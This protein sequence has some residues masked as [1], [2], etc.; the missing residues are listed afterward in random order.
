MKIIIRLIALILFLLLSLYIVF[1]ETERYES[2]S[3]I[4]LKDLTEKQE[5]NL[6]E[7][8]LGKGSST[9]QDSK[10]IELYM[11][12]NEMYDFL[13]EKFHLTKHYS[14]EALDPRQRLYVDALLPMARVT[15][16]N[17]LAKYNAD[18]TIA[19]DDPSGTLTIS[20]V[21][22]DPKLAK[23]M[24]ES[25]YAR[26][27]EIINGFA[28]ENAKVALYFIED[29][30]KENREEFTL[31]IKKLIAYQNKHHTIDPSLDVE[32]KS[33]ILAEL[34]S[35]LIKSQV[36]Y[37]SKLKS[38]NPKG[39]EM[40]MLKETIRTL[41][42][43]ILRVNTQMVG[44]NKKELNKNVFDFEL[45]KSDMEFAKEVY[46]QTLINQEKLKLEVSQKS[47]HLLV[48][49]KPSLADDYTY[50]N[51]IWDVFKLFIVIMFLYSIIM[52]IINIVRDHKD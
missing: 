25:M 11:R 33:T 26:A 31:S 32:R 14:S 38:W 44:F 48:V 13:D 41:E 43:S 21:H 23:E 51:K 36:E 39:K 27:D 16:K 3:I 22:T 9:L 19:Y 5:M 15:K 52:T 45:L 47:R 10:I 35:E 30:K 7:M 40:E 18:L 24:L 20:M 42:K 8:L 2:T 50:P 12:S 6:G 4:L 17:L 49:A 28:K 29:I 34:E 46:R 1:V 37:S